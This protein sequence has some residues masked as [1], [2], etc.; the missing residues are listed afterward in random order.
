MPP[1]LVSAAPSVLPSPSL[2]LTKEEETESRDMAAVEAGLDSGSLEVQPEDPLGSLTVLSSAATFCCGG[3]EAELPDAEKSAE[4]ET[5][6]GKICPTFTS[7]AFD[8]SAS[9]LE[10]CLLSSS[11]EAIGGKSR[12]FDVCT[13]AGSVVCSK[14]EELS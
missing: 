10:V 6:D 2:G 4:S 1:A 13:T 12:E 3:P 14:E 5:T 11:S 7:A 8:R 9:L